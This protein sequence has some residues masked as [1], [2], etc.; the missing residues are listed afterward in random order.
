M[1]L[2]LMVLLLGI[3]LLLTP[4]HGVR[5]PRLLVTYEGIHVSLLPPSLGIIQIDIHLVGVRKDVLCLSGAVV[6]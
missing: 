6:L 2:H 5:S 4:F 3:V 1:L